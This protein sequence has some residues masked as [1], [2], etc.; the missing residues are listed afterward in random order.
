[1]TY[2]ITIRIENG[3][4]YRRIQTQCRKSF[5]TSDGYKYIQSKLKENYIYFRCVLFSNTCKGKS[6][7][8][9]ETNLITPLKGHNHDVDEYKS[10]VYSLKTKCKTLAK[11]S[12]TTLRKVF[13]YATRDGHS[14]VKSHFLNVN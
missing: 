6:K 9:R 11:K 14:H 1:M 7:L 12:Q 4:Y 3:I 13:D 2:F 8:N 10:E 5:T